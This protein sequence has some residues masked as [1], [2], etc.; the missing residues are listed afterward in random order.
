MPFSLPSLSRPTGH[1]TAFFF[2]F[3]F[4][5]SGRKSSSC[6]LSGRVLLHDISL[7]YEKLV[8]FGDSSNFHEQKSPSY[9]H[10]FA[11]AKE[12]DFLQNPS[13]V[14]NETSKRT[15]KALLFF[16]FKFQVV[17]T[18]ALKASTALLEKIVDVITLFTACCGD[19]LCRTCQLREK[20]VKAKQRVNCFTNELLWWCFSAWNPS[21]QCP[22]VLGC[23]PEWK[24]LPVIGKDRSLTGQSYNVS[25]IMLSTSVRNKLKQLLAHKRMSSLDQKLRESDILNRERG[26]KVRKIRTGKVWETVFSNTSPERAW[27][28]LAE[29]M[30]HCCFLSLTRK[31]TAENPNDSFGCL[32]LG[33][34]S[35]TGI[36]FFFN[37]CL[38]LRWEE[39]EN[40]LNGGQLSQT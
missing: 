37:V 16:F 40:K 32:S 4:L 33:K 1:T 27:I 23:S 13:A 35:S 3:V 14:L 31:E 15:R 25:H 6:G 2:C 21:A 38:R 24:I 8:C 22:P 11:L 39:N 10:Y 5:H 26:K 7:H 17:P 9:L 30:A 29:Q 36:F 28:P 19:G 20:Y 18:G 12:N 34:F